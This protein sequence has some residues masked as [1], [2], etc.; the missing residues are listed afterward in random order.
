MLDFVTERWFVEAMIYMAGA[1]ISVA[2]VCWFIDQFN[3]D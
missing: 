1:M 3:K 2:V